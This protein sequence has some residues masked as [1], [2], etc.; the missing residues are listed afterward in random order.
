MGIKSDDLVQEFSRQLYLGR[1]AFF[2]GSGLSVPSGLPD[3]LGLMRKMANSRLGIK[4]TE[5][6]NL[7]LIAQ[8]IV[9]QA[10][11]NRGPLLSHLRE[12]L[13]KKFAMNRYHAALSRTNVSTIWTT[14]FD[15]LIEQ[16]MQ[17]HQ[18]VQVKS[19]DEAISCSIGTPSV[20]VVKMHG[21]IGN[22]SCDNLVVTQED[23]EEFFHRR[24]AT[25]QKLSQDLIEKSFLFVG[26]SYNDPNVQN[27][28]I[29]A[30]RLSGKMARPHFMVIKKIQNKN[31]AEQQ[32]QQL[33][34]DLWLQDLS[35]LGIY[36]CQIDDF[37]DLEKILDDLSL[38]SRGNSIFVTGGHLRSER[39]RVDQLKKL[40]SLLAKETDLILLDGQSSGVSR[41]VAS[42]YLEVCINGKSEI[43]SRVKLF[44]N[45]Y[46]A[47]PNFSNDAS[48]LPTLKEWR[49]PLLKS[50]RIV[51]VF[52]GGIGT[53]AE[54]EVAKEL[55]CLI[56][57]VPEKNGDFPC[58]LLEDKTITDQL[59]TN[60]VAL[61]KSLNIKAKDVINCIRFLLDGNA[62]PQH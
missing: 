25:A 18:A 34:Q 31:K 56:V 48:L 50:A 36:A 24:P 16:A 58:E 8:F 23:Y 55:G 19:T 3:W 49:A 12:T 4:L 9:N 27:V 15:T 52:D 13:S 35:R 38:A 41:V 17:I 33:R 1:G 59:G 11:G 57:P 22:G 28:V 32:R 30:R 54:V 21:C 47:N 51:V 42:K 60:Y 39:K 43:H 2:V 20:E 29:Q 14:N 40:G 46:A 37:Q 62:C 45:P 5:R 53:R 6:D 26:Y 44:P 61:A 10:S 7:P